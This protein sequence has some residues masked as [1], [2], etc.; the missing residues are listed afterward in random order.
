MTQVRQL[1]QQRCGPPR[2]NCLR[3]PSLAA[4]LLDAV[5]IGRAERGVQRLNAG[6]SETASTQQRRQPRRVLVHQPLV[7]THAARFQELGDQRRQ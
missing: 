7:R 1:G 6:R 5:E 2:P 3:Q 4:R